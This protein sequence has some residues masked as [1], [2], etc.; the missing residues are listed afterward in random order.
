MDF[1]E[2]ID[3]ARDLLRSKRR[4]T[5][6]TLKR[7]FSLDDE[8]LNDLKDE[9]IEAERVAA[10]EN[11][12]ILVWVGDTSPTEATPSPTPS[13]PREPAISNPIAQPSPWKAADG[14]RRQLTVMFC[15]LVGSTALSAKMDPENLH[16]LVRGF[17]QT[18][19]AAIKRYDGYIAQYLG[20]GLLV[21][22]G[23]PAAHEDDAIR[24]VRTSL[25]ILAQLQR[26][27]NVDRLEVRIGIHT[28]LVVVGEVGDGD[29]REQLAMGETPNIAARLQSVA[30]PNSIV[31][32]AETQHL[33]RG[34]F[35]CENLGKQDLKGLS[36]GVT[37]FRVVG[38]GN[39][40][41]R[42]DVSLQ[43]GLTP[44][45]GREEELELLR[46]RW[47]RAKAGEGQVV[48]LSGEAG[49]GKS[50]L[51]QA[52][53]DTMAEES[54]RSALF[55]CSPYFQN[56]AY[57]PVRELLLKFL[58][59]EQLDSPAAKIMA[60]TEA[61]ERVEMSDPET[62]TLVAAV[63][64]LQLPTDYAP[65]QFGAQKQKEQTLQILASWFR[66]MSVDRP[67]R[68]EFEDL[69]WADPST[70]ELLGVL[71]DE[72]A[73]AKILLLLTY[74]PEFR[75][76]WQIQAH[77]LSIYVGRLSQRRITEVAERVAGKPLPLEIVQQLVA[78]SDG[79]PLYIEEMTKNLVESGL[80][81]ET[82]ERF[83]LAGPVPEMAI[84]SS[85]QDSFAARLDRLSGVRHLAQIGAVFGRNFTFEQLQ[86]VTRMEEAALL[87]GLQQLSDAGIFYARGLPPA[88]TYTFKHALLQDA[89]Y[90][91][92]LK[93]QRLQ[94]H[95]Q[96]AHLLEQGSPADRE[97][98]PEI[99]ARHYAEAGLVTEAIPYWAKAG[100]RA[101]K[102]FANGEAVGHFTMAITALR[103]LPESAP[104]NRQE[105]ELQLALGL[106]LTATKGFAAPEVGEVYMRAREL[107][108]QMESSTEIFPM[109]WGLWA[110]YITRAEHPRAREFAEQ[111]MR[112]GT[113]HGD[114]VHMLEAHFANGFSL[115]YLGEIT[116]A[117][118]QL[119][120][121]NRLYDA[122]QHHA[123]AFQYGAVDR[124]VA[125]LCETSWALWYLGYP[126]QA[127]LRVG[128]A[129]RLAQTLSHSF[130]QAFA[131]YYA[132]ILHQLRQETAASLESAEAAIAIS[133][134]FGFPYQLA[135]GKILKGAALVAEEQN[136]DG[137]SQTERGLTALQATGAAVLRS[138]LYGLLAEAYGACGR[139]EDG[140]TTLAQAFAFIDTSE[141]RYCEPEL[142]R[143]FGE[144][145]LQKSD[146]DTLEAERCFCTAIE[147]AQRQHARA[148]ELRA[149]TSLARLWLRQE[150]RAAA[151]ALLAPVYGWFTEG[152]DTAD[153]KAAR[154]LLEKLA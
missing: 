125:C 136:E 43:Q 61:L 95:Q 145:I 134:K 8:S 26:L 15:D 42:F 20:D 138:Y 24:A 19:G 129:L 124:G 92:L 144:I 84:P 122:T 131:H 71:I 40:L 12:A 77:C 83:T 28:G 54:H 49:I 107:S 2:I 58:H 30:A 148:W 34:F 116:A 151:A 87:D 123:L 64:A 132:A 85:L 113:S 7:Q 70:L 128:G 140:L 41:S 99:L 11:G 97:H 141:E 90:A 56:S 74:R 55:R 80:L 65:L 23:Y 32:S 114:A 67:F 82:A 149:A 73:D 53:R 102:Q 108:E 135:M 59:F 109:L 39:A 10:D 115:L 153:L 110:F 139:P 120:H 146:P 119:E 16:K 35:D 152:F 4:V 27:D 9:L 88:T 89:A 121:A 76:L 94:Y 46:R 137:L 81:V 75:P 22:F 111:L 50:R 86:A 57:Y 72:I 63:L 105:F 66:K 17:Q 133:E 29:S 93:S 38:T 21:Y 69:H 14:G 91:S 45:V 52:L 36:Q 98:H 103:T 5:Y 25:D 68:V 147:I 150:K 118:V 154:T 117:H 48:L 51:T 6:K 101:V 37:I 3:Q 44:L 112:I 130:S 1:I 143:L 104:R 18:C 79:V 31:I 142:H 47:E 126:D 96:I 60:L 106:P 62:I 33:V 100:Q 78:K 127:L 13:G